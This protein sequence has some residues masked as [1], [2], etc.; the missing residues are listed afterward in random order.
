VCAGL[1]TARPHHDNAPLGG[2][3]ADIEFLEGGG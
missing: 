3:F 1:A 2:N